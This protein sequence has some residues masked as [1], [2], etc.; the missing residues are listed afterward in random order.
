MNNIE[1]KVLGHFFTNTDSNVYC[2]TDNMPI[3]I[4]ALLLGGYSRSS[5]SLRNRLLKLF[6]EVSKSDGVEYETY[7]TSLSQS[8]DRGGLDL[9]NE[10]D[11]ASAFLNKFAIEYGHNSLKDSSFNMIAIEGVSIKASKILEDSRQGAFQEKSTRYMDFSGDSVSEYVTNPEGKALLSEAMSLYSEAKNELVEYYKA[12]INR[13]DFKT[14]NA[15]IRTANAKAFDDARYI[16]PTSIKTSLGVT[17]PTRETERWISKLLASEYV[18][19]V[20]LA[21]KIK[22]ECQKIT[23]ALIKHVSKNDYLNRKKS[24]VLDGYSVKYDNI[25]EYYA[26]SVELVC[27]SNIETEVMYNLIHASGIVDRPTIA[28]I[29]TTNPN[30]KAELFEK[31]FSTRGQFDE[32]PDETATGHLHFEIVCDIGAFRDIQR[33]RR[34]TQ[35]VEKWNAYRGY[36]I[37]DVLNEPELSSL[38]N[39]YI[40]LFN[41]ISDFNKNLTSNKVD[42]SEYYLLL[43]HNVHFIYTCDFKQFAYLVELRSG[44]S[45]HYSYRKI[46][47][48]MYILF[49]EK[50]PEISKYIRVNMAGYTDRRKAEEAIQDKISSIS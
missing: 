36:S 17:M 22:T 21:E 39:R 42:D 34:G 16:L 12:K 30:I 50:Y 26:N 45:G 31:A 13:E 1:N 41:N 6:K 48:Y 8:I 20:E 5:E 2:A 27:N 24:N 38:K 44:E 7:L 14:E 10:M 9:K 3:S 19:V 33:H 46:A 4:W 25:T 28:E 49:Q 15:W 37:P 35:V 23:P 43:G 40:E 29:I 47:Q 32:F 11:R 18:E